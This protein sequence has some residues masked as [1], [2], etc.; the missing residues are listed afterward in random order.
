M[1]T[2][3]SVSQDIIVGTVTRPWAGISGVLFLSQA[4][5]FSLL[6]NAQT[7]SEAHPASYSMSIRI[8]FPGRKAVGAQ[9]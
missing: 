2:V 8:S 5:N 7:G 6:Q 1:E 4:R 9:S 3:Y